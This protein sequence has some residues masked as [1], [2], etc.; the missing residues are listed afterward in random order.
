MKKQMA[1]M[2]AAA[3]IS[4]VIAV[5][6]MAESSHVKANTTTDH[7]N[8]M[9]MTKGHYDSRT[10]NNYETVPGGYNNMSRS[11]S[12]NDNMYNTNSYNGYGTGT[13][14]TNSV[15]AHATTSRGTGWG[16]LG[17]L[18]LFGL[19]GMRREKHEGTPHH[20]K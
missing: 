15:N 5:P 7:V 18:G 3:S 2:L 12:M 20:A 4:M 17:L 19:A 6:A 16:W 9:N 10:Y 8:E 13:Y 14:G 11:R 1:T